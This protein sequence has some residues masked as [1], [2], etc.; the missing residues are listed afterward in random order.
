MRRQIFE[1]IKENE[2]LFSELRYV[3]FIDTMSQDRCLTFTQI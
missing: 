2:F 3:V 1:E